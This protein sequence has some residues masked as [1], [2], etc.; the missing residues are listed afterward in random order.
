M[1][2]LIRRLAG[3]VYRRAL[4]A[5]TRNSLRL[6]TALDDRDRPPRSIDLFD[7]RAVVVIAPH[8]DDEIAGVGGTILRHV[9]AGAAVTVVFTTDGSRGCDHLAGANSDFPADPEVRARLCTEIRCSES[10]AACQTLGVRDLVF[11]DGP[12]GALQPTPALVAS[13]SAVLR[14]RNPRIVYHPSL[15]DLHEDHWQTNAVLGHSLTAGALSPGVVLRG[16]EVWTPLIANAVV[17]ISDAMTLKESAFKA[18]TS[19]NS[20]VDYPRAFRGLNAYRSIHA[21][22]GDGYAEAFHE[23]DTETFQRL[24]VQATSRR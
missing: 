7:T 4:S 13:L 6:A 10:R 8:M 14:D 1:P 11:L 21:A 18:F 20:C 19:Q 15:L 17:D 3:A 5:E 23:T 12:D 2:P 16:Y 22:A 9:T 24:R